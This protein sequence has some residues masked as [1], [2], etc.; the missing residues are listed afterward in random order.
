MHYHSIMVLQSSGMYKVIEAC[1]ARYV[2]SNVLQIPFD[3]CSF[4]IAPQ[5][6]TR[7]GSGEKLQKS[8]VKLPT[9]SQIIMMRRLDAHGK[10]CNV[11]GRSFRRR[12][13][14][15]SPSTY[16]LMVVGPPNRSNTMQPRP[17]VILLLP[18]KHE[19]LYPRA[20]TSS[21]SFLDI[22]LRYLP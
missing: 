18:M 4:T 2:T 8:S 13:T 3:A 5:A 12:Y 14:Q 6:A 21:A 11:A 19:I 20:L 9:A 22:L 17:G 7:P 1:L 15:C 10:L 16:N